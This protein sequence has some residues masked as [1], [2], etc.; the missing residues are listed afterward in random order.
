MKKIEYFHRFLCCKRNASV[1]ILLVIVVPPLLLMGLFLYD[2]LLIRH[3]ESK[4]LKVVFAV[5]EAK[6]AQYNEYLDAERS[7]QANLDIGTTGDYFKYYLEN[8]GID[9]PEIAVELDSLNKPKHFEKTVT[10]SMLTTVGNAALEALLE[11]IGIVDVVKDLAEL[12]ERIDKKLE[13]LYRVLEFPKLLVVKL[14]SSSISE[15]ESGVKLIERL[16]LDRDS[17]FYEQKAGV[18][19]ELPNITVDELR[20]DK[21]DLVS[22]LA[23]TWRQ[24]HSDVDRALS[25]IARYQRSI[26]IPSPPVFPIPPFQPNDVALPNAFSPYPSYEKTEQE[27][28]EY[29]RKQFEDWSFFRKDEGQSGILSLIR[30]GLAAL[31]KS[32]GAFATEGGTLV[33]KRN[34]FT[35]HPYRSNP[36]I[37]EKMAMVEWIARN[38]SSYAKDSKKKHT[39]RGEAE[40]I[41]TGKKKEADSVSR[42]R[43]EIAGIRLIPNSITFSKSKVK[44]QVTAVLGVLPPPLNYIALGIAYSALVMGESYIDSG[45]L[46]QGDSFPFIKD[47]SDWRLSFD[48]L[49]KGAI[50]DLAE[51]VAERKKDKANFD[52]LDYLRILL[53]FE[54]PRNLVLRS[55]NVVEA[56]ILAASGDAYTLADYSIGHQIRVRFYNKSIVTKRR[57]EIEFENS[58]D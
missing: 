49:T 5:S 45:R 57:A 18:E 21:E 41:V 35:K 43:L 48:G 52:Y 55:M 54:S 46:L 47:E 50:G 31:K 25:E 24:Y 23:Q 39:I 15:V 19:S 40:Y 30:K 22:K 34:D 29:V 38:T 32:L 17:L 58:Y 42:I 51:L 10:R 26:Q 20:K 56:D 6:L 7:L 12:I 1:S 16:L 27:V 8:N 44:E 9:N 14:K 37:L 28:I 4:A 11:K 3:R 53:F 2:L 33:L 36:N 13:D